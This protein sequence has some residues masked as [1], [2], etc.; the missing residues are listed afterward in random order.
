MTNYNGQP[1]TYENSSDPWLMDK[2]DDSSVISVNGVKMTAANLWKMSTAEREQALEDV[3]MYYRKK[4]FPKHEISQHE[5]DSEFNK[6]KDLDA[7]SCVSKDGHLMNTGTLCLGICKAFCQEHYYRAHGSGKSNSLVE[8]FNDDA[9]LRDV[10]KNRMGW[11]TTS[12]GGSTRP[13]MFP[14]SDDMVL[15]GIRNSG[16]GYAVS[17]FRPKLAKWMYQN[18]SSHVEREDGYQMSVFDYS[19]GWG[20]RLLGAASLGYKYEACDPLTA[21]CVSSIARA[22]HYN[23]ATLHS[24]CS[25]DEFFMSGEMEAKFDIIGSCPPYFDLEVYSDDETQS[26]SEFKSYGNWLDGYWQKTCKNI[27]HMIKDD[28]IAIL[29]TKDQVGKHHLADDMLDV[30]DGVGFSVCEARSFKTTT[31]HLSGKTK[32]GRSTKTNEHMYFLKKR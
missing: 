21:S 6:L 27:L 7:S 3:F 15:N 2:R 29:A 25:Q 9:K 14:I 26:T 4:G 23:D 31:N 32:T 18:A 22:I 17:N 8:V 19:A 5:I 30:L 28:G 12:E 11:N 13:Y 1:Y 16:Y 10:L 20:A 24:R